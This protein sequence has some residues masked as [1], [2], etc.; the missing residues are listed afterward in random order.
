MEIDITQEIRLLTIKPPFAGL[1]L[2]GKVET[3]TWHTKYLGM[4]LLHAARMP[5]RDE[6]I[7]DLCTTTQIQ[8]MVSLGV[9]RFIEATDK[10]QV[11]RGKTVQPG[12]AFA[13][14]DLVD[15]RPMQRTD[16]ENCFVEFRR[17]L[18]CH[19]YENIRP[20]VPF[21]IKGRQGFVALRPQQKELIR[22]TAQASSG[23]AITINDLRSVIGFE[24]LVYILE[25]KSTDVICIQ[26][27]DAN[28][29]SGVKV[30]ARFE[31]DKGFYFEVS[32]MYV[33]S[34][35]IAVLLEKYDFTNQIDNAYMH[36]FKKQF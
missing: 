5:Y 20:I 1:M 7:L 29:Y 18:F 3:R 36:F 24:P 31:V 16:E 25:K 10:V 26:Q 4:V 33:S 19:I 27:E 11:T 8:K 28:G 17:D 32:P 21:G 6:E 35:S 23:S 2:H 34:T 12:H 9:L 13:V 22:L 14:A 15:C 30:S